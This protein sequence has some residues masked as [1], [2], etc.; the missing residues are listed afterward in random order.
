MAAKKSA[1]YTCAIVQSGS[2]QSLE[3]SK[4]R[5]RK[6]RTGLW[7][8]NRKPSE[9]CAKNRDLVIQADFW[10]ALEIIGIGFKNTLKFSISNQVLKLFLRYSAAANISRKQYKQGSSLVT[11]IRETTLPEMCHTLF[12]CI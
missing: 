1:V 4:S 5:L 3:L 11:L 12:Y 2:T 7:L 10:S 9:G 6:G 8:R